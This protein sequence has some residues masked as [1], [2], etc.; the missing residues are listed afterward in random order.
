MKIVLIIV[1]TFFIL[2]LLGVA[3]L[4]LVPL[5]PIDNNIEIKIV[6]S[7]SMEPAIKTGSLVVITPASSYGVGDVITFESTTALIPTTHRIVSISD[8]NGTK[9]FTTKGDANEEADTNLVAEGSVIGRVFVAMPYAGFILD[10]ARQPIGF[11]LLIVLPALLIIF[12][13]IEKIWSEIRKRKKS[14]EDDGT[15][16]I[17]CENKE[18]TEAEE[19]KIVRMIEIGRPIAMPGVISRVRHLRVESVRNPARSTLSFGD[20]AIGA[21]VGV[22]SVCFASLGFIGS[23]VSYFNDSETASLNILEAQALDFT[24][25]AD[26]T[27]YGFIGNELDDEDGALISITTPTF[28]STD[29]QYEVSTN[30]VGD[31]SLFCDSIQVDTELPLAYTGPLTTLSGANIV[32]DGPWVLSLSLPPLYGP[33]ALGE[34]C[35]IE[36]IYNAWDADGNTGEGYTD[37]EIITLVFTAPIP[38]VAPLVAPSFLLA[39]E[40]FV[41]EISEE[42]TDTIVVP[43]VEETLTEPAVIEEVEE[44]PEEVEPEE[45]IEEQEVEGEQEEELE[46]DVV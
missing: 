39:P 8:E 44:E 28:G 9:M 1:N 37:E 26:S 12:G 30:V 13:E 35:T 2:L 22:F 21:F 41:G 33:F 36:I 32:F 18:E 3:G 46:G 16:T 29:I 45:P 34:T 42:E 19:L 11:S 31:N 17:L 6:E 43:P 15:P 14:D 20:V 4:F 40:S 10:F 27:S 38:E 5:L 23:T 24:V 7:G 25:E